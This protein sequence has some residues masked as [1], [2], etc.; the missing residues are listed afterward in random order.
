MKL[1]MMPIT[2]PCPTCGAKPEV[3]AAVGKT[4]RWGTESASPEVGGGEQNYEWVLRELDDL[5]L[6]IGIVR[7]A[8]LEAKDSQ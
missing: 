5:Q 7:R 6:A 4:I 2:L 3:L 8:M 1:A